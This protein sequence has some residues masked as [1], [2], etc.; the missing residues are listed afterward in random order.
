ML[1]GSSAIIGL[2]V[3]SLSPPQ[4]QLLSPVHFLSQFFI[5]ASTFNKASG[6]CA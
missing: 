3:L 6:V 4:P 5:V 1:T 2:F